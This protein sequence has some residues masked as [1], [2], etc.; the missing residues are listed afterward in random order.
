MGAHSDP[1]RGTAMPPT[2]LHAVRLPS[3]LTSRM[4]T[5]YSGAP[6]DLSWSKSLA[7]FSRCICPSDGALFFGGGGGGLPNPPPDALALASMTRG[8][9]ARRAEVDGASGPVALQP[10]Q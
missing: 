10:A 5:T 3:A 9:W 6:L 8:A 2:G 4:D 1:E 7:A